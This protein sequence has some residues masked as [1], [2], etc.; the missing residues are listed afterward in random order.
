MAKIIDFRMRPPIEA[1]RGLFTPGFVDRAN[2]I[3]GA[4]T[5]PSC[6]HV[7]EEQGMNLLLEEMEQ[8]EIDIGVMNGRQMAGVDANDEVLADTEKRY[9][10][11]FYSFAC[12]NL[13]KPM[14]EILQ[15]IEIAVR[16]LGLR[17]V[18]CEPGF[19]PSP[20]YPDDERMFPIYEKCLELEVPVLFMTGFFCGPD[21][22]WNDPMRFDR[23]AGAFPRLQMVMGHGCYPYV[24]QAIGLACKRTNVYLSPDCYMFLPGGDMYIKA[25]A[26]D[27]QLIFGTAYP[28]RPLVQTVQ[29]TKQFP[30]S[31]EAMDKYL[32][33]NAAKLLK[34]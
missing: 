6:K 19:S 3:M 7:G 30:M 22:G 8:A 33:G 10:G 31:K 23:V 26:L 4:A 13:S 32:Y 16:Q 5:S 24:T 2:R 14:D 1:Y 25:P 12:T 18:T 9:P 29:E 27:D 21:I 28:F 15:G 11:R 34:L 20:M 17:G